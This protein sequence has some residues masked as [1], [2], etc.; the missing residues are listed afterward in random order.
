MLSVSFLL[1]RFLL[2][3]P[4][5]SRI[6]L[7]PT[8]LW[9]MAK[10]AAIF[11]SSSYQRLFAHL[12]NV[13][14]LCHLLW[15]IEYCGQRH[16][17]TS[18]PRPLEALQLL[19]SH[20]GPFSHHMHK[21]M[22]AYYGMRD[23]VE[24]GPSHTS[25]PSQGHVNEPVLM[26]AACRHLSKPSS[27]QLSPA[28]SRRTTQ[29]GP[30]Y[31]ANLQKRDLNEESFK[32]TKHWGRSVCSTSLYTTSPATVCMGPP[33]PALPSVQLGLSYLQVCLNYPPGLGLKCVFPSCS[34]FT[35]SSHS[36]QR[37]FFKYFPALQC[38]LSVPR[39]WPLVPYTS[40]WARLTHS[41]QLFLILFTLHV[42]ITSCFLN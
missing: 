23:Y 4:R 36:G 28:R 18:K 39:P 25:Q 24:R 5:P 15:P 31:I 26:T 19:L 2:W 40:P 27:D 7:Q 22:I 13:C 30:V 10:P 32:A 6:W 14:W 38:S 29:L 12:L 33:C 21:P 20:W 11:Y 34:D 8:H 1:R 42:F 3:H 9:E 17:A 35:H 37:P 16:C 41:G